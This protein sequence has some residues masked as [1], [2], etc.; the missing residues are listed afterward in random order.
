MPKIS[1]IGS[2]KEIATDM[3]FT[4]IMK[5]TFGMDNGD[6]EAVAEFFDGQAEIEERDPADAQDQAEA[7]MYQA[8]ATF[9]RALMKPKVDAQPISREESNA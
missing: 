8:V 1:L 7:K 5:L 2:R 3:I 6:L 4:G 9:A